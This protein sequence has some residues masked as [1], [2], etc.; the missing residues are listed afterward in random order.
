MVGFSD[1]SKMPRM[2]T[3]HVVSSKQGHPIAW[4]SRSLRT[5]P[6]SCDIL[7]ALLLLLFLNLGQAQTN[8]QRL[9]SFGPPPSA[10]ETTPNGK[11]VEGTNGFLY[12][13][14]K[15]GG[16][17]NLGVVFR[18]DKLG[19]NYSTLH[20]FT[21]TNDGAVPSAGLLLASD[22]Q[23]YGTTLAGGFGKTGRVSASA[24]MAAASWFS[25]ISLIPLRVE[26]HP[27]RR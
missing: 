17:N 11:L 23:F 22:G 13:T 10:T 26:L 25:V 15:E 5:K 21:G 19:Q 14:T 6:R 1:S 2:N 3:D 8:F 16:C 18:C 27:L 20:A 24:T 9:L 12:G 7:V 4:Y